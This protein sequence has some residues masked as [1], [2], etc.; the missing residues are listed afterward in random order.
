VTDQ[1]ATNVRPPAGD[2]DSNS[3]GVTSEPEGAELSSA[4]IAELEHEVKDFEDRWRRALADFDNLRKR[5]AREAERERA[6]ERARVVGEWLPILDN[7]ELAL[8]HAMADPGAVVEGV[9]AVRDQALAV[10]DR[11]GFTRIDDVGVP[12]D[13]TVHEAIGTVVDPDVPPGTVV[14]VVRPGYRRGDGQ[15]RPAS[16]LVATKAA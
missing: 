8:D 9:Q 13:P 14:R 16:V 1:P 12:F 4:R 3:P 5:L 11:L 7:L 15:L 6:D 10:L 2:R